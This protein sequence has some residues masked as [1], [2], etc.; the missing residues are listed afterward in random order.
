M[1]SLLA[2]SMSNDEIDDTTSSSD[3]WA[4]GLQ[5]A[6]LATRSSR[7]QDK[8][9]TGNSDRDLLLDHFVW[10]EVLAAEADDVVTM[11]LEISVV[12]R[13]N[14][15]LAQALTGRPDVGQLLDEAEAR[16]L[17]VTALGSAGWFQIHAL[18]RAAL[19]AEFNSALPAAVRGRACPRREMVRGHGRDPARTGALVARPSATRSAAGP[20][21]EPRRAIRRQAARPPSRA[22]S[23]PSPPRC[24]RPISTR[25]STTHGA[26]C[27]SAD[28]G[29]STPCSRRAGG[30][31]TTSTTPRWGC[32]LS[33][34]RSVASSLN[35]DWTT[36]GEL[37]REAMTRNGRGMVT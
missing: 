18:V 22:R 17:F 29:T 13:V 26:S 1:L 4:A 14:I 5:L 3:G 31:S 9:E 33:M 35:G 30:S 37:A 15:S 34:L 23:P 2:P 36:A 19:L 24:E 11:L 32:R 25:C 10:H 7:A 21:R 20:R 6:A 8:A 27:S 12:D 28:A 16:G